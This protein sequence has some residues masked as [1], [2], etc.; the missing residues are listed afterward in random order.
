[1]PDGSWSDDE[2]AE[3]VATISYE[4]ALRGNMQSSPGNSSPFS[5]AAQSKNGAGR[6]SDANAASA[7][8]TKPLKTASITIRL[9]EP[10]CAQLRLRAAEAGLTVSAYLRSCTQEV[11]SLRA[12]VK[13]ALAELRNSARQPCGLKRESELLGPIKILF[14]AFRRWFKFVRPR[15]MLATGLNSANP[16]A[17]VP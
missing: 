3:D 17:P 12:Q 9:S 16:F 5:G 14:A 2:L 6:I 1:M 15:K 11:E 10:E 7:A 4:Q 8:S 13:Q